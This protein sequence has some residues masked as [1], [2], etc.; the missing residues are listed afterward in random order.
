VEAAMKIFRW[1][2]M[3]GLILIAYDILVLF[4]DELILGHALFNIKM[5]SGAIWTMTVGDLLVAGGLLCL[6]IEIY[7]ST[8]T[9]KAAIAGHFLSTLVF[10]IY[11]VEFILLKAAGTPVFFFLTLMVLFGVVAGFTITIKAALRDSAK[12]RDSKIVAP[13]ESR[14]ETPISG[15]GK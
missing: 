10:V 13:P 15:T 2:P 11:V 6:F 12:E 7:K 5:T 1:F 4:K 3:L 14:P 8:R 9:K